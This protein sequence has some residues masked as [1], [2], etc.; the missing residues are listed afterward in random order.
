MG[1]AIPPQRTPTKRPRVRRWPVL[2]L[3]VASVLLIDGAAVAKPLVTIDPG[4]GGPDPGAV[5]CSHSF[6]GKNC[7][8]ESDLNQDISIRL[9]ETLRGWGLETRF[10]RTTDKRV[11]DPPRDLETW[12]EQSDGSREYRKDGKVDARDELQSR[13]NVANCGG[14][15]TSCDAG[16]PKQADLFVSVHNNACGSCNRGGTETYHFSA[17]AEGAKLAG[18]VQAEVVSRIQRPDR[19][20]KSANFYVIRFTR[21]PAVLVE[22]AFVDDATDSQ[23]LKD[24]AFR[25]SIADGIAVG[26]MR[27]LAF[28]HIIDRE[29]SLRAA[30]SDFGP[31]R[32]EEVWV[33]GGWSMHFERGRFY[34]SP[35]TGA[36]VAYGGIL[37][38][39]LDAGG[40]AAFGLPTTDEHSVPGGRASNFQ[41]GRIY[42]SK[43][44]GTNMVYGGILTKYLDLGGPG[45]F[46]KLPTADERVVPGGRVSTFQ[47]GHVY[48]GKATGSKVVYGG[49]LSKFLGLGG[50]ASLGLPSTD[51]HSVPGGRA[52]NFQKGRIYW[53]SSTGAKVVYGGILS[54]YLSVG[55]PGSFAGLPTTDE[56]GAEGGR[57]SFFQGARIYWSSATGA[58][59]VQGAIMRKY[60]ELG[61]E[62]FIGLPVSDEEGAATGRRS[63]FQRGHI[64]WAPTT[65]AHAV[66]GAILARYLDAGGPSSSLGFPTSDEYGVPGGRRSDFERGHITWDRSSGETQVTHLS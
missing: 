52:S 19:G 33:P 22:S 15:H 66:Y 53:S 50:P 60:A 21:M 61:A 5:N 27:Y 25:Q 2:A 48:W 13:V 62:K 45:S 38:K 49:I 8:Q 1:I 64:Y 16:D 51:E 24:P 31:R 12:N 37:G 63:R 29:A 65:G 3:A 55:G 32:T 40:P 43:A 23:K 59:V 11:N 41:K 18:R 57:A 34:W 42:W 26:V 39:Y 10:T 36:K 35:G 46:L 30:G 28:K 54:K 56:H 58:R 44:T 47:G 4:H 7:M 20:V 14:P 17:S 9:G 6:A